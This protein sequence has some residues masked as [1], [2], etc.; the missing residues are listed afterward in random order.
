V[1]A[2]DRHTDTDTRTVSVT[3][4]GCCAHSINGPSGTVEGENLIH[5]LTYYQ[6]LKEAADVLTRD[7]TNLHVQWIP[8]IVSGAIPLLPPHTHI[9][10]HT[11][12]H[13]TWQSVH[14][15]GTQSSA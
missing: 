10:T 6:L 5:Q 14:G 2:C 3:S 12:T 11:H 15:Q 9:H 1:H 13:V 7:K 4:T 8:E